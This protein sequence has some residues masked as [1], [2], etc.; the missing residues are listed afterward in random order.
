MTTS[1]FFT[2]RMHLTDEG[3]ALYVD[4]MKLKRTAE[5]PKEMLKHV[6]YCPDCQLQI[7]ELYDVLKNEVYDTT[8]KHPYFDRVEEPNVGYTSIMYRVAAVLAGVALLG[9]GYYFITTTSIQQTP[10]SLVEKEKP[11]SI[12]QQGNLAETNE[13]VRRK[14]TTVQQQDFA[15]NFVESP[16]LEDLVQTQ[17]RSIAVEVIT[18]K[19]G[20]V[21]QQPVVFKWKGVNEP[22]TIK[23]LSNKERTLASANVNTNSYTTKKIL[24][25]GLYYWKLETK[26]EVIYVGKFL[27][28]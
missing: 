20:D 12:E 18:P 25:P 16:N 26:D 27:V 23:I 28:R 3:V 11:Q 2:N 24:S 13:S 1:S 19:A 4:A 22:L 8:M 7:V 17:F 10:P 21:V 14:E 9:V 6:E 5:L 15:A